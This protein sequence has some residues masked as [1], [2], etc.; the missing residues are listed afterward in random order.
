MLRRRVGRRAA[1]LCLLLGVQVPRVLLVSW[2]LLLSQV[3]WAPQVSQLSLMPLVEGE[4][5]R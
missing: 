3:L 5:P 4:A 1:A 2:V